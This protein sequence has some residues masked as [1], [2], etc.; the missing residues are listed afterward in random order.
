[1]PANPAPPIHPCNK[2]TEFSDYELIDCGNKR[3]LERFGPFIIDRPAPQALWPPQLSADTWKNADAYYHRPQTGA[4]HWLNNVPFPE[5]WLLKI[6][7]VTL[8]LRPSP[9]GQIGIFPEQWSNWQWLKHTLQQQQRPLKILN[10]F[11]YTGAATLVASAA[12]N[13]T[14]L[15]HLDGARSSVS[16]AR[17]NASLSHLQSHTIRWVVDDVLTFLNR[18][19][20]RGRR[21]DGFILDPPAFGRGAKGIWKIERDLPQLLEYVDQLLTKQASFVLLSCHVPTWHAS[22]LAKLLEQL[23]AFRGNTA[24]AIDLLIPSKTGHALPSSICGRIST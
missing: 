3:R 15:C 11:A 17:H 16:W 8:Q 10:A 24:E 20:K 18:E 14:E 21:Y 7:Q 12:A 5:P 6:G 23:S 19:I 22:Y 4:G 1:M 2:Q 13:K 9:N